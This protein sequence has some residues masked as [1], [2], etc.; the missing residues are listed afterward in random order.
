MNPHMKS[1]VSRADG[2]AV[3][4]AMV[5]PTLLTWVYFVL[6]PRWAPGLAQPA[7][8]VGKAIQFLFPL[9][10]V[11]AVRRQRLAPPPRTT[12]GVAEGFAFG[13]VIFA[14]AVGL[15]WVWL[16]PAGVIQGAAAEIETKLHGF[17]VHGAAA[18]VALGA[19]YSIVH[20][21]LEEYF[22]RWFVF[23]QLRTIIPWGMAVAVSS[24]AFMAHHVILLG[25]Y[26]GWNS[27]A[28]YVFSLAVAV[29]GAYWA[30][31]YQRSRSLYGPWVSHLLIDAVIFAVGYDL[32]RTMFA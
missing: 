24:A 22:W 30:W 17:G 10:W 25:T 20:S 23:G 18:Y 16:R 4:F 32:V 7:Y 21:F 1:R 11:L 12:A 5:F 26:F 2:A 27:P 3:L 31:L 29:G 15:Y 13:T 19:F 14:A 9:A 6:L 8:T 28:T